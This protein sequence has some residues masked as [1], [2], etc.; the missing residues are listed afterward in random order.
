MIFAYEKIESYYSRIW[1]DKTKESYRMFYWINKNEEKCIV[2][3]Y[4]YIKKNIHL[5]IV[6]RRMLHHL[7]NTDYSISYVQ[8]IVIP[9]NFY[10]TNLFD[11]W[12]INNFD[13]IS[14]FQR[15]P[16]FFDFFGPKLFE[17]ENNLLI[18]IFTN[19]DSLPKYPVR[20]WQLV[21]EETL[22]GN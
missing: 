8:F 9:F 1:M 16:F 5:M 20:L 13:F 21:L 17:L 19:L 10:E 14:E 18:Y 2:Y 11:E 3:I 7:T 4:M 15:V 22:S 6:W 12:D